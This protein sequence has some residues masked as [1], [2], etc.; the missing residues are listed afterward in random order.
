MSCRLF[1]CF[2]I[3]SGHLVVCLNICLD[4]LYSEIDINS[5]RCQ[6]ESDVPFASLDQVSMVGMWLV[7]EM[8]HKIMSGRM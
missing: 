1:V 2:S 6:K 4:D 8:K 5:K 3:V 7:C